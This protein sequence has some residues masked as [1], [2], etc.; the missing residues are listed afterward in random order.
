[1]VK[2]KKKT[3]IQPPSATST[4]KNNSRLSISKYI[5]PLSGLALLVAL[6]FSASPRIEH[7]GPTPSH[8]DTKQSTAASTPDT[9]IL[10]YITPWN[11]KGFDYALE[12]A[13]KITHVSPVWFNVKRTSPKKYLIEGHHDI[14]STFLNLLRSSPHRS[15]VLPR[16]IL[17]DFQ[18]DDFLAVIQDANEQKRLSKA[19]V[20]DCEKGNFDG[21]TLELHLPSL[22]LSFVKTISAELKSRQKLLVLVIGPDAKGPYVFEENHLQEFG[23]YVDRFSLMTYDHSSPQKPGP[24]SPIDWVRRNIERLTPLSQAAKS[25]SNYRSKILT[26]FNFYGWDYSFAPSSS[27]AASVDALT[28]PQYLELKAK[29]PTGKERWDKENEETMYSY[30]DGKGMKHTAWVPTVKSIKSRVKLV[31]QTKTGISIWELGQ[32]VNEFFEAL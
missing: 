4:H 10:G 31:K 25:K 13:N 2:T 19:I 26:G 18:Q 22:F 11:S 23:E 12:Y 28:A 9:E 1:M 8:S 5:L 7:I 15:K 14:N 27:A 30:V 32:G 3:T 16:Y 20:A 6:Y 21:V 17:H 29:Y 24:N